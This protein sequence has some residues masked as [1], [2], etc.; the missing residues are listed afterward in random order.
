METININIAVDV[1]KALSEGTLE[2]SVFLMDDGTSGSEGAGTPALKTVCRPGDLLRWKLY[3]IDLQAGADILAITFGR[4]IPANLV[5]GTEDTSLYLNTWEGIVPYLPEGE[6]PYCLTLR[7]GKGK[8]SVMTL[9][10][11]ALLVRQC[12]RIQEQ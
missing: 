11:P 2:G 4:E 9:D 1:M 7:I 12:G 10:T 8:N 3:P 6:Y 5:C